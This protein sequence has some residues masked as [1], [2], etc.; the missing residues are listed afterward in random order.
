MYQVV[1]SPEELEVIETLCREVETEKDLSWMGTTGF[2]NAVEGLWKVACRIGFIHGRDSTAP[3]EV[4]AVNIENELEQERVWGFDVGWKLCNELQQSRASQASLD[5][6]PLLLPHPVATAAIQAV[7]TPSVAAVSAPIS[8]DWAE[9]AA[10]LPIHL[11]HSATPPPAARDFSALI[12]GSPKPFASLQR[13]RRRAPRPVNAP[14]QNPPLRHSIHPPQKKSGIHRSVTRRT[15][16][17]HSHL[18]PFI[19]SP[20][21]TSFLPPDGPAAPF[22]LDWDQDPRLRDLA[23]ALT[24]LGWVKS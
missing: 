2:A 7:V 13:R 3:L 12:T 6:S 16:P 19:P 22:P 21:S 5:P 1:L 17:S 9:D 8:L 14:L 24:A 15:P 18:P 11:P 10:N 4:P 23:R 20:A